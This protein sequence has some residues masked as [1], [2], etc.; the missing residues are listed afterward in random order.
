MKKTK[1]LLDLLVF[2]SVFNTSAE[3]GMLVASWFNQIELPQII[4]IPFGIAAIASIFC[5]VYINSIKGNTD[6]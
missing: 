6:D 2:F 5:V 1:V 4:Y 3:I